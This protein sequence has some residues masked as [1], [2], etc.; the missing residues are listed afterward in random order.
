MQINNNICFRLITGIIITTIT[1]VT[2]YFIV[3]T[4]ELL[5]MY[6]VIMVLMY[7]LHQVRKSPNMFINDLIKLINQINF[8]AC[9]IYCEKFNLFIY[10]HRF[11]GF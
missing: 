1:Y 4:G 7:I 6:K 5:I 2:P 11:S 10:E 8:Y 3:Q 9:I